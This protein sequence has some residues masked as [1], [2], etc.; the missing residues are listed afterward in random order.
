MAT[1]DTLELSKYC[2]IALIL[3]MR[4][5]DTNGTP[6]C[7]WEIE[8]KQAM[9]VPNVDG[10]C[11]K[12]HWNVFWCKRAL[13]RSLQREKRRLNSEKLYLI[14]NIYG[15]NYVFCMFIVLAGFHGCY[16]G[17]VYADMFANVIFGYSDISVLWPYAQKR[18][19]FRMKQIFMKQFKIQ[20][21]WSGIWLQAPWVISNWPESITC[22]TD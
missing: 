16:H 10:K 4:Y 2:E 15:W 6:L 21:F 12:V 17:C 7:K 8:L 1:R 11:F 14:Q 13:S 18:A 3:N 22:F 19:H 20:I 5:L 9:R